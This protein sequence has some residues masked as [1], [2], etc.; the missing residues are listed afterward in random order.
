MLLD[1]DC[2]YVQFVCS[3]GVWVESAPG[4]DFVFVGERNFLNVCLMGES[5]RDI[6]DTQ[7]R[8]PWARRPRTRKR[9]EDEEETME[10]K[11]GG[12]LWE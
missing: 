8:T 5:G 3:K 1:V 6:V 10:Q 11:N 4:G 12:G 2:A 9:E 7:L